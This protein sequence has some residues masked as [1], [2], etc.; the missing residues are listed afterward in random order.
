MPSPFPHLAP[1][2]RGTVRALRHDARSLVGNPLGDPHVRDVFVYTPPGSDG[3]GLPAVLLL[4]GY[5]GTGEKLLARG[6]SDVPMST[7]ID[8]LVAA[9]C[10]PFV[11][12]MPD[13]MTSLGGCQYVDSRGIGAYATWLADE[14]VQFVD[15]TLGTCGRWGVAGRSSGGFGALHLALERPGRFQAAA[16]HSGDLGFDLCYLADLAPGLRAWTAA[17][18]VERFVPAFWAKEEPSSIDFAGLNLLCMARA[19]GEG[20]PVDP[21]TGAVDFDVLRR[22]TRFDPC[23]RDLTPLRQLD[24]LY[25]DVGDRDEHGLQ[26]G[27]RRLK[28]R[29]DDA[30]IPVTYQEFAGG[31]RGNLARWDLSLTAL[32][33]ALA[34]QE[35]DRVLSRPAPSK[36]AGSQAAKDEFDRGRSFHKDR[37]FKGAIASFERAAV[38]DPTMSEAAFRL[39]LAYEDDRNFRLAIEAYERCLQIKPDHVQAA[40]NIGESHRKNERYKDALWAYDRALSIRSDYPYGLAGRGESMRMLGDYS[41]ALQWFDHALSVAPRHAFAVQGKAAALN[42]LRRFKEALPLWNQ[43]LE[44]DPGSQFAKDGKALCESQLGP[45]EKPTAPKKRSARKPSTRLAKEPE[46]PSVK[47]KTAKK[48][49]RD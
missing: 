32:A 45:S 4:P 26:F 40:C 1:E 6:L 36:P 25:I 30:N 29:L 12:V 43:A 14:L 24:R 3:R 47:P 33:T 17:G 23:V 21:A 46:K 20:L 10:P 7:R 31:H 35:V 15:A 41:G 28:R 5:S 39:G 19:Y 37:D 42:A 38:L 2:L 13:V 49:P 18:G 16:C 44:I 22:W 34:R 8:R 11:A 9:G 48:S 27:A